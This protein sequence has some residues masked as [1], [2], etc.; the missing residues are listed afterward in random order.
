[1]VRR[2]CI[3]RTPGAEWVGDHSRYSM[4]LRRRCICLPTPSRG[5]LA[6]VPHLVCDRLDVPHHNPRSG[7]RL[8]KR[9]GVSVGIV[10]VVF[11]GRNNARAQRCSSSDR[12][13][14]EQGVPNADGWSLRGFSLVFRILQVSCMH[15]DRERLDLGPS[16][17]L[18]MNQA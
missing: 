5:E 11:V 17:S 1:M 3:S 6:Q 14:Y 8:G 9:R 12:C 15:V 4:R 7:F 16:D 13:N 10:M 2:A 18:A